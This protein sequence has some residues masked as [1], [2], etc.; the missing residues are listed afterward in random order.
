MVRKF[1]SASI[2]LLVIIAF[3][4]GSQR[5]YAAQALDSSF[6]NSKCDKDSG[7]AKEGVESYFK[8]YKFAGI[9]QSKGVFRTIYTNNKLSIDPGGGVCQCLARSSEIVYGKRIGHLEDDRIVWTETYKP[10]NENR[11]RA[12]FSRLLR[13]IVR[14]VSP[15]GPIEGFLLVD[16]ANG[17]P[18]VAV[19]LIRDNSSSSEVCS[20]FGK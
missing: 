18:S 5:S 17:C 8:A 3:L 12:E 14:E 13:F 19:Q 1:S 20:C 15:V 11:P 9:Y 6:G 16:F 7:W 2:C 10:T 4:L